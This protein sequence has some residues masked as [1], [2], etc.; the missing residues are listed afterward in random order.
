MTGLKKKA[1]RRNRDALKNFP[2]MELCFLRGA[3]KERGY[4][5]II[6]DRRL[7]VVNEGA[8]FG[9][10]LGGVQAE[11]RVNPATAADA[12]SLSV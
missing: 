7:F 4:V 5:Q 10:Y 6:D 12:G 3:A 11:D 8:M 9:N 2:R 1:P